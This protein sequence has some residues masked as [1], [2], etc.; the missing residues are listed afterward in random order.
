MLRDTS[1]N[2]Y[3]YASIELLCALRATLRQP[4]TP[5]YQLY[6]GDGGAGVASQDVVEDNI[7]DIDVRVVSLLAEYNVAAH[8]QSILVHDT[9]PLKHKITN[10]KNIMGTYQELSMSDALKGPLGP[11][12][13]DIMGLVEACNTRCAEA[14]VVTFRTCLLTAAFKLVEKDALRAGDLK[15]VLADI[16]E[17]VLGGKSD[18]GEILERHMPNYTSIVPE[19]LQN[20]IKDA[21]PPTTAERYALLHESTE[22]RPLLTDIMPENP[23]IRGQIGRPSAGR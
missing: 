7:R 19:Q 18:L 11:L 5:A 12:A 6:K 21:C 2:G 3:T 17:E 16:V 22:L 15:E 13:D 4:T 20:E 10:I 23:S 8:I 14:T 9:M 1:P